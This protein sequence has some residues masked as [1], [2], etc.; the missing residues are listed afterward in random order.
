MVQIC[1]FSGE[2]PKHQAVSLSDQGFLLTNLKLRHGAEK[3]EMMAKVGKAGHVATWLRLSATSKLSYFCALPHGLFLYL[4]LNGYWLNYMNCPADEFSSLFCL[5]EFWIPFC[6][7]L[8]WKRTYWQGIFERWQINT[9][10]NKKQNKTKHL[11]LGS[12]WFGALSSW[13]L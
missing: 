9:F 7:W 10:T 12:N 1:G 3:S 8:N 13:F 2:N 4:Q 11:I 6:A 5:H